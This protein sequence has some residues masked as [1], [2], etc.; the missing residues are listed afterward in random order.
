M[1]RVPTTCRKHPFPFSLAT[2]LV[3]RTDMGTMLERVWGFCQELWIACKAGWSRLD[4]KSRVVLVV[5]GGIELFSLI[6]TTGIMFN[7]AVF[8]LAM[9]ISLGLL[10]YSIPPILRFLA[11]HYLS[12]DFLMVC[13]TLLVGF[14]MGPTMAVSLMFFGL[15]LSAALRMAHAIAPDY[16]KDWT[17]PN[18]I[19]GRF[20]RWLL[21][22]LK[23]TGE[24][25]GKLSKPKEAP[26]VIEGQIVAP[27]PSQA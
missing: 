20:F 6:F 21:S 7:G 26:V 4:S 23:K 25:L 11:D 19:I 5:A 17:W 10:C 14:F 8:A 3:R 22:S 12:V 9:T 15:T 24:S 18:T 13:A 16:G 2:T 1:D 27:I